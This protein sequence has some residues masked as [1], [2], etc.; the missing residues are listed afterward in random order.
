MLAKLSLSLTAAL[1]LSASSDRVARAATVPTTTDDAREMAH[2]PMNAEI[3]AAETGNPHSTGYKDRMIS[4]RQSTNDEINAAERGSP[5][6]VDNKDQQAPPTA[7]HWR[8]DWQAEESKDPDN[9]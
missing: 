1:A 3:E 8:A 2:S 5:D 4:S 7:E 6:S 9:P